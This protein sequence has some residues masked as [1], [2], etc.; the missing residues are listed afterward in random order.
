[1]D[2]SDIESNNIIKKLSV[3]VKSP[4]WWFMKSIPERKRKLRLRK[5]GL[6]SEA[7]EAAEGQVC[8]IC[9]AGLWLPVQPDVCRQ[10]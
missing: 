9:G 7:E 2:V 1:M 10:T 6:L 3:K 8:R 4:K 5:S